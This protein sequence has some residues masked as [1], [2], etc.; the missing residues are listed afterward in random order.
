MKSNTA[1]VM[2][3][4]GGHA[5]LSLIEA[6]H[7]LNLRVW[8]VD[9]RASLPSSMLAE[10]VLPIYRYDRDQILEAARREHTD[11][12]SSAGSDKAVFMMAL[13][14][15]SLGIPSYVPSTVAR[16]PI[17]KGVLRDLL[18]VNDVMVPRTI[19]ASFWRELEAIDWS[20]LSFPVVVKP[21]GGIGQTAVN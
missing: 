6:I 12:V 16:L 15:E 13:A 18:L 5:Q 20:S 8:I 17:A 7:Y 14:A 4:G 9:D 3:I 21:D 1:A 11:F 10:R 19:V 2:V